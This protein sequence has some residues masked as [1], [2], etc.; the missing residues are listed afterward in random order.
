MVVLP[1]AVLSLGEAVVAPSPCRCMQP[2]PSGWAYQVSK[3][4]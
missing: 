3:R 4:P 1:G 2:G